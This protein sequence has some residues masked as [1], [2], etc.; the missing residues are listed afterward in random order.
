MVRFGMEHVCSSDIVCGRMV[1]SLFAK[2]F[3]KI[4]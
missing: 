3:V 2:I 4:L 1:F